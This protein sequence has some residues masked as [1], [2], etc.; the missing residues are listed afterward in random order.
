M[1]TLATVASLVIIGFAAV[2]ALWRLA[3]WIDALAR[4]GRVSSEWLDGQCLSEG[5]AGWDGPRW[6]FEAER[7]E[8]DRQARIQRVAAMRAGQARRRV[9]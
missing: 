8:M 2:W 5:R 1:S 3:K 7:K 4:R 6:R 9:S